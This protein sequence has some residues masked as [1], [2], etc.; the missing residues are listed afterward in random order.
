LAAHYASAAAELPLEEGDSAISGPA[1]RK[2]PSAFARGV[3]RQGADGKFH[4]ALRNPQRQVNIRST[5]DTYLIEARKQ[6]SPPRAIGTLEVPRVF[7]DGH[8]GAIYLHQGAQ[9]EVTELDQNS[10]ASG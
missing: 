2:R 1:S 7:R 9:W 8:Q 10:S 3:L 6:G 4:S 5:G